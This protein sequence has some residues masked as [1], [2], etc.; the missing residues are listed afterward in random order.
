[1][2][3]LSRTLQAILVLAVVLPWYVAAS[4]R[5]PEFIHHFLWKH[6]VERFVTPFDHE[7]PVWFYLPVLLVGLLPATLLLWPFC[8]FLLS[9]KQGAAERRPP[10]LGFMLLVSGW[11]V[12]FFSL[13]GCKLLARQEW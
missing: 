7:R 2:H 13:S 12:F 4:I 10:E 8:R 6:N 3:S 5:M 9:G 11:C 1:M